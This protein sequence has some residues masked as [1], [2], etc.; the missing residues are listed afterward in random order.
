M[1]ELCRALEEYKAIALTG[2]PGV[3]KSQA[4]LEY[5]H[6]QYLAQT[7]SF[8]FWVVADSDTGLRTGFLEIARQLNLPEKDAEDQEIILQAV[9]DWLQHNPGY[10]LI[11]DNV[12]DLKTLNRFLPGGCAGHR[13]LTARNAATGNF[14]PLPLAL[15]SPEDAALFL[16]RRSNR[17]PKQPEAF[18]FLIPYLRGNVR[19]TPTFKV[20]IHKP[21][22]TEGL[23]RG[24]VR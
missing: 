7:Y 23:A 1:E 19:K 15:L 5:G 12:E 2:Q 20:I 11:L 3:G 13:L 18:D 17:D 22:G 10:L 24:G 16:L 6:Q 21:V 4:A 9:R 14:F 8:V